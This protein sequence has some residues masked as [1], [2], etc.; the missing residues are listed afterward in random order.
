[1]VFSTEYGVNDAF[2]IVEKSSQRNLSNYEILGKK[3]AS[4]V[5]TSKLLVISTAIKVTEE[6]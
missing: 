3:Q 2:G 1:M 6:G 4:T 5:P